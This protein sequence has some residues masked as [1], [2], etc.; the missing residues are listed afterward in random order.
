MDDSTT[1]S[2][3]KPCSHRLP[4]GESSATA[5]YN[6]YRRN[7]KVRNLDWTITPE[8]FREITARDCYFCGHPPQQRYR[9]TRGYGVFVYNGIDRLANHRG[10]VADNVVAAC[11][12]CNFAKGS[13]PAVEFLDWAIR[14]ASHAES[15]TADFAYRTGAGE[16]TST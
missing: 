13:R 1:T 14:F 9:R 3:R 6:S 2:T 4:A 11:G 10:Y 16:P 15:W 5:V 12:A 7:A 8:E